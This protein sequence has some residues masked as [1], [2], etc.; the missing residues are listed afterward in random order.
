M[1]RTPIALTLALMVAGVGLAPA[2]AT[3]YFQSNVVNVDYGVETVLNRNG[4]VV[5]TCDVI[6]AE[7]DGTASL[8]TGLIE[9]V[10]PG[11]IT[12]IMND[13]QLPFLDLP[14]FVLPGLAGLEDASG[15]GINNNANSAPDPAVTA[16]DADLSANAGGPFYITA[17]TRLPDPS[18]RRD[19]RLL[20]GGELQSSSL[21]IPHKGP[22]RGL[23]FLIHYL[24]I[25]VQEKDLRWLYSPTEERGR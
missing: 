16:F 10:F 23:L 5:A 1:T 13:S 6:T 3:D 19:R 14:S 20:H 8:P 11:L 15:F 7:T 17:D 22:D 18:H 4:A 2:K 12:Q 21:E 9:A 24:R 25:E